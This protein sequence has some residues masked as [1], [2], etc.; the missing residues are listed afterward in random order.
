MCSAD[1]NSRTTPLPRCSTSSMPSQ[2]EH[3]RLLVW[4][5]GAI[6]WFMCINLNTIFEKKNVFCSVQLQRFFKRRQ[7]RPLLPTSTHLCVDIK[8]QR[9]AGSQSDHACVCQLPASAH[10]STEVNFEQCV[11]KLVARVEVDIDQLGA[12]L[13]QRRHARVRRHISNSDVFRTSYT[14]R[15]RMKKHTTNTKPK[16][17]NRVK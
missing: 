1:N 7:S 12:M 15:A 6:A 4:P 8:K 10:E 17:T 9:A 14:V 3:S 11:G 13:C 5:C 2:V 16:I